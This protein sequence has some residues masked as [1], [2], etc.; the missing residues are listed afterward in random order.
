MTAFWSCLPKG[1][2]IRG[3]GTRSDGAVWDLAHLYLLPDPTALGCPELP[4]AA[5][6]SSMGPNA[7][8]R[9]Q[10]TPHW[11]SP[12]GCEGGF[13]PPF[14]DGQVQLGNLGSAISGTGLREI[15]PGKFCPSDSV[16]KGRNI[17]LSLTERRGACL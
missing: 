17:L 10:P 9:L 6:S 2:S 13:S 16:G 1:V 11:V 4:V 8:Q 15:A 14:L 12:G 7:G 5:S 3:N